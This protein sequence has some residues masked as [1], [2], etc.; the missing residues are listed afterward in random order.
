MPSTHAHKVFGDRVAAGYPAPLR[1]LAEQHRALFYIGL[2]GP[3][4]LF[5][6]KPL[7]VNPVNS[8]G[9][10]QHSKPAA[11]F[12]GPAAERVRSTPAEEQG[13]MRAY[14][15]G[16]L[17]HFALDSA[18][19]GYIE[20]KIA[21]SGVPHTEIEGEFDRSLL[22]EAGRD[23]LREDLA[24]HIIPSAEAGAVI[25]PFFPGVTPEQVE[26]SLRSMRFYNRLLVAPGGPK[27][28]LV[29]AVLK[30]TGNYKEM[31]GMLLN[32]QPNPACED[33]SLR[34]KKLMD[35]AV[36]E[37][38]RLTEAYWPCLEGESPLPREMERTFG[39][40]A[41]WREIPV[42]PVKEELVYEV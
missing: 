21:V 40:G 39:P 13:P 30:V 41:D 28:A 29:N 27:R 2:H 12:F 35:R 20:H 8:V 9:F 32:R 42:L 16:F 7:F 19:H 5:Y 14:L 24:A 26:R 4:I 33:S 36:G 10:G 23:P 6:Y 37:C 15:L 25:A 18:C 34:L 38:L 22:V 1:A 31:H 11:D 3:D 17:C